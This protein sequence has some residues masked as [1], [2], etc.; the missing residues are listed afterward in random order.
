MTLKFIFKLVPERN[1]TYVIVGSFSS[2]VTSWQLEVELE[3]KLYSHKLIV[4]IGIRLRRRDPDSSRRKR[5]AEL[6]HR[7]LIPWEL[8]AGKCVFLRTGFS[9]DC[10]LP[11]EFT[12][13]GRGGATGKEGRRNSVT[14]NRVWGSE[15]KRHKSVGNQVSG[16]CRSKNI[17]FTHG[18]TSQSK[19]VAVCF[20]YGVGENRADFF[21]FH[22]SP[23]WCYWSKS[24]CPPNFFRLMLHSQKKSK[25]RSLS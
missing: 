5:Q 21:R 9:R 10:F 2:P 17:L 18:T 6:P 3:S 22:Q 19:P 14:A 8:F 24:A 15:E 7:I 1:N 23:A 4:K 25:L 16:F 12:P 11:A 13:G 20:S